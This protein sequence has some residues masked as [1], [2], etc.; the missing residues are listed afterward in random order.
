MDGK[1]W[2]SAWHVKWPKGWSMEEEGVSSGS[3]ELAGV[4]LAV[5]QHQA[6]FKHLT[7]WTD[8]SNAVSAL[9]RGMSTKSSPINDAVRAILDL[10]HKGNTLLHVVWHHRSDCVSALCADDLSRGLF[11]AAAARIPEISLDWTTPCEPGSQSLWKT[12]SLLASAPSASNTTAGRSE[13]SHN[14]ASL[15][16][17]TSQN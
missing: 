14:G 12:S 10:C 2:T 7:V 8:S 1:G 11:Q 4:Y 13:P 9:S 17:P 3:Q 5:K 15:S 6:R 16:R